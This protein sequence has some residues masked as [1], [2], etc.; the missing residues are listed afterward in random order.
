M[1]VFVPYRGVYPPA[2]TAIEK[3]ELCQWKDVELSGNLQE[4]DVF[5]LRSGPDPFIIQCIRSSGGR[6]TL[7]RMTVEELFV[8]I[9]HEYGEH[10]GKGDGH[11]D[12]WPKTP[13]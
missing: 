9:T 12:C 6:F 11:K 8:S 2:L 4:G 5:I 10:I 3:D 7:R 1:K 13:N